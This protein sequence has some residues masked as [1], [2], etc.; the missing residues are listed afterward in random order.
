MGKCVMVME[1]QKGNFGE[2][3]REKEEKGISGLP[4]TERLENSI[5]RN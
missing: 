2:Q 4:I 3:K 5:P 1:A